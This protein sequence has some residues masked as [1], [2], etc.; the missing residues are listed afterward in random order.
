MALGLLDEWYVSVAHTKDDITETI[1]NQEK[2]S[3]QLNEY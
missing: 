2:H 3:V 1:E